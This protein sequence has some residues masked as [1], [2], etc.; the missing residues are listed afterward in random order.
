MGDYMEN[1]LTAGLSKV[2]A[3]SILRCSACSATISSTPTK[4]PT[5]Q[6][7]DESL[8]TV[9]KVHLKHLGMFNL[10]L[11]VLIYG[12]LSWGLTGDWVVFK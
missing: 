9:W 4:Q 5:W 1:T 6:G 10:S 8:V 2:S 3:R 11:P 7:K 12:V